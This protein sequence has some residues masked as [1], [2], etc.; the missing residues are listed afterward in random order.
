[1]TM[2]LCTSMIVCVKTVIL[3][4]IVDIKIDY[5]AVYKTR[6]MTRLPDILL[7]CMK[8]RPTFHYLPGTF[9]FVAFHCIYPLT[10]N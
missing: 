5:C 10:T 6:V 4:I 9:H 3:D 7:N 8:S 1:M 2:W